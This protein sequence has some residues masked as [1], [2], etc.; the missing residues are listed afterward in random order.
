[1]AHI[2]KKEEEMRASW[3]ERTLEDQ[4]GHEWAVF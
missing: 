1:M 2:R 3:I 4:N